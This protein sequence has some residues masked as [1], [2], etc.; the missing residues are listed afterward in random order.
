MGGVDL[1]DRMISNYRMN[2]RTKKWAIR[3]ILHFVDVA[4]AN[5]WLL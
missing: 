2:G 4:L 1:A 5:S 3:M